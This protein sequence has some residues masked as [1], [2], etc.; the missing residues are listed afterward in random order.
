MSDEALKVFRIGPR[1]ARVEL[2]G[3]YAGAW[4]DMVLNPGSAVFDQLAVED[5]QTL[6]AEGH[7][8]PRPEFRAHLAPLIRAWN[9]VDAAGAPLPCT[10]ESLATL[11][12][13]LV[14]GL[15]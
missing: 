2:D 7:R 1:V 10:A 12:W 9:L 8:F 6:D 3:E 15:W 11:D 4:A 13:E 5:W 14:L